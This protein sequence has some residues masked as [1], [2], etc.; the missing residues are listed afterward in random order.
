MI[1]IKNQIYFHQIIVYINETLYGFDTVS[2]SRQCNSTELWA[3]A[4]Y[5]Y[6]RS[7]IIV[8]I[9]NYFIDRIRSITGCL[10]IW[11]S[12]SVFPSIVLMKAAE[13]LN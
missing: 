12:K 6:N 9:F 5:I 10:C 4:G 13:Y 1:R 7:F 3:E 8:Y 11:H 2:T